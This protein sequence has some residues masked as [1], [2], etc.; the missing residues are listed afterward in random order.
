MGNGNP[1]HDDLIMIENNLNNLVVNNKNQVII[2]KQ[3]QYRINSLTKI[4]NML[5]N[6]IKKDNNFNDDIFVGLLYIKPTK[7]IKINKRNNQC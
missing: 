2:N 1:D 4:S 6:S 5:T 3:F 7:S